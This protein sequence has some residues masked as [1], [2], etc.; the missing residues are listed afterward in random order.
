MSQLKKTDVKDEALRLGAGWLS[1]GHWMI[2]ANGETKE[3]LAEIGARCVHE[4]TE[5]MVSKVLRGHYYDF[6]DGIS[7]PNPKHATKLTSELLETSKTWRAAAPDKRHRAMHANDVARCYR[8]NGT[9]VYFQQRYVELL[10]HPTVAV[11][12]RT[13]TEADTGPWALYHTTERTFV[14]QAGMKTETETTYSFAG[15]LMPYLA[16]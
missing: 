13:K 5:E 12:L 15:I 11:P 10:G 16:K 1:N 4:L 6:A 8:G 14:R 3:S 7:E 9:E 2:F